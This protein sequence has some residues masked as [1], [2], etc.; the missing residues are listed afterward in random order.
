MRIVTGRLPF[1]AFLALLASHRFALSPPGRGHDCFRTW[2]ALAVGTTP[3]VAND[4]AFASLSHLGAVAVPLD[5]EELTP[6]ALRALLA[7]Q[8]PPDTAAV[9][10]RFWREA[11]A[12]ACDARE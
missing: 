10:V 4:P 9:D 1:D 11:F 3:L 6:D 5:P 12:R 2:Q 8:R 7:A